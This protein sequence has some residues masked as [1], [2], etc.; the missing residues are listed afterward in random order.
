MAKIVRFH[1]LGG[2]EVSPEF[3]GGSSSRSVS[4]DSTQ[5]QSCRHN[6]GFNAQHTGSVNPTHKEDLK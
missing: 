6:Y 5:R 1:E 3:R 4:E 2:P